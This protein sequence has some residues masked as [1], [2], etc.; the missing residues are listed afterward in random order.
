VQRPKKID[1]L[2][3]SNPHRLACKRL[4]ASYDRFLVRLREMYESVNIVFQVLTNLTTVVYGN[5]SVKN[6]IESGFFSFF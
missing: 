3:Q 6:P 2:D 5:T 4:R 1:N